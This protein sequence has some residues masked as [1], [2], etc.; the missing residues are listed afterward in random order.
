MENFF[1]CARNVEDYLK[2][3]VDLTDKK[4]ADLQNKNLMMT[5]DVQNFFKSVM[6]K[7]LKSEKYF[8]LPISNEI[9]TG[10]DG[11]KLDFNYGLRMEIPKGDWRVRISDADSGL[12]FLEGKIS[13]KRL[14]SLET[15]FIRW[16]VEIFHGGTK[17][18]SHTLNLQ[19]KPVKISVPMI[20]IGDVISMLPYIER[21]RERNGCKIFV[22][23]REDL[24][25]FAMYLYPKIFNGENE[26]GYYAT[27]YPSMP[28]DVIP[29]WQVDFRNFPM[30][31]MIGV[32]LG[33]NEIVPNRQFEPTTAPL[34]REPYVCISVQ[35]SETRKSWLYPNGWDV[36][37]DY[38]K[39]LGYRVLCIDRDAECK[40]AFGKVCK[41]AAAE[42]FTGNIPLMER[43]NMIFYADFFIGLSSGLS[44]LAN[45][46]SCPVVLICGFS[47]DWSEFYTPYR[48]ANRL[49]CGGCFNDVRVNYMQ[50]KCPYHRGTEREFECQKKISPNQVISAIERLIIDYQLEPPVLGA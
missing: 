44:W 24:I 1:F 3:L 42:D 39:S 17:I 31:R 45:A 34:I 32:M 28:T 38:L 47:Q 9:V 36:V 30:G 10:I 4:I 11:L 19:N 41:P 20:G 14:C 21:F 16:N 18:F 26:G 13:D 48:V 35:G 25:P 7:H 33:L 22:K 23:M 27:Y 12:V 40:D 29:V 2:P 49:V 6:T 5:Q 37:V 46:V 8:E 43:A 50:K 15:Y